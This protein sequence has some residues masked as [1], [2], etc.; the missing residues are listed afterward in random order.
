MFL[1]QVTS[2]LINYYLHFPEISYFVL[3]LFRQIVYLLLLKVLL[4]NKEHMIIV[5]RKD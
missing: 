3:L 5:I 2:V 1:L 4:V